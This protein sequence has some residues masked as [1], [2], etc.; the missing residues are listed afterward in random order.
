M[1]VP[2]HLRPPLTLRPPP[3]YPQLPTS[4]AGAQPVLGPKTMCPAASWRPH[5]Y[6]MLLVL[7]EHAEPN[8]RRHWVLPIP[9]PHI[10]SHEGHAPGATLRAVEAWRCPSGPPVK[11]AAPLPTLVKPWPPPFP[12]VDTGPGPLPG[13]LPLTGCSEPQTRSRTRRALHHPTGR[14]QSQGSRKRHCSS[15]VLRGH[16]QDAV[17]GG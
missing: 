17:S 6:S 9:S 16:A 13:I 2:L 3:T 5:R 8:P 15:A 14:A 10:W 12:S 11:T 4:A 7:C 1:T